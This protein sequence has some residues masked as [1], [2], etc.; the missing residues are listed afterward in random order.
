MPAPIPF[1]APVTI[2]TLLSSRFMMGSFALRELQAFHF[3]VSL[4]HDDALA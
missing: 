2:A 3:S 4:F 1:E